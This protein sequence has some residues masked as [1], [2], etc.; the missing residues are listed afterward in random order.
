MKE[1]RICIADICDR[2]SGEME[3]LQ[4]D[5]NQLVGGLSSREVTPASFPAMNVWTG[6]D[7]AVITAEVPGVL[8]DGSTFPSWVRH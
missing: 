2:H 8:A 4:R 6:D 5:M 3:R 7:T 1:K